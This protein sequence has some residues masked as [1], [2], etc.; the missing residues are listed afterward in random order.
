MS[1]VNW[2]MISFGKVMPSAWAV[3]RFTT[4]LNMDTSVDAGSQP[5][6]RGGQKTAGGGQDYYHVSKKFQEY[7]DQRCDAHCGDRLMASMNH[8]PKPTSA[9]ADDRSSLLVLALLAPVV[10]AAA[11]LV[12]ALIRLAPAQTDLSCKTLT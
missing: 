6:R 9:A 7:R 5:L 12:G 11:G 10:G 8:D 4:K 3:L 1:S 2:S